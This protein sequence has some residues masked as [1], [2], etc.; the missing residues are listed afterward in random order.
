MRRMT[1]HWGKREGDVRAW[2]LRE[3]R[4]IAAED[5]AMCLAIGRHGA[6]LIRDGGGV[7]THC[8][9]GALA[10]A[11]L[12]TALAAL[13]VAHQQGKRFSVFADETRPLLQGARLTAWE[14]HQAGIDVTLI[15]D[16]MAAQVMR[17]GR[18]QAV[19]VGADR[20][21]ANGDVANKIGTYS[22]AVLANAHNVPFDRAAPP[23]GG[24][25]RPGPA[26]GPRRRQ[27]VQPGVRRDAGAADHRRR[28]GE[29]RHPL[30]E[31]GGGPGDGRPIG[32]ASA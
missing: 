13:F 20:I 30:G 19:I 23:A 14:L 29:G 10:T 24:D 26:D 22:V 11:G 15:C 8:N 32:Q 28:H 16:S 21:A 3:A 5:E 6:E 7:L 1:E 27:G 18:V 2:L 17:E 9:T 31:R 4:Q 12:G 25:A